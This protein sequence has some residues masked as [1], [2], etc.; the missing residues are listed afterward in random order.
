[1]QQNE[2]LEAFKLRLINDIRSLEKQLDNDNVE[3]EKIVKKIEQFNS[4]IEQTESD[5]KT[6]NLEG[7]FIQNELRNIRVKLEKQAIK[8][9]ELEENILELLQ[10]QITTDKAGQFRTKLLRDTQ[11][12]RRGLEINMSNTENQLSNVLLDL[13]AW[14]G[15][16]N[17]L[18]EKVNKLQVCIIIVNFYSSPFLTRL[19]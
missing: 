18:K 13:E 15:V 7:I 16:T 10:D 2:K 14:K 11:E 3:F 8:K 6:A 1:M 9:I 19:L 17:K 4:L 12:Q 5:L